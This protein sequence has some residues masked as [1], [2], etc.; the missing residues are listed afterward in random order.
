MEISKKLADAIN[1]QIVHEFQASQQY[2]AIAGY[3]KERELSLLHKLF[4][5][6]S[7]E[8]RMHALKFVD[9][10]WDTNST[11]EL[12]AIPAAY[13]N[14]NSAEEAVEGALKWEKEVTRRINELMKIAVADQDFQSQSFFKWFID[15]QLEEEN[16]MLTLLN[17]VRMSGE[18]NLLMVEAYMAHLKKV[19]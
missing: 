6:Q 17:V 14:M 19:D 11:L 18:K 9:Y 8:E 15:E 13:G 2:L 1:D 12:K 7:N 4:V 3:F 5:K 10:I 16:S